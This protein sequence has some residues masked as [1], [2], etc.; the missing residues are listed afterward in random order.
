M[1]TALW[2]CVLCL[3]GSGWGSSSACGRHG[4][5]IVAVQVSVDGWNDARV[6][7][8]LIDHAGERTGWYQG[9]AVRGIPGCTHEFGSE[10]GLPEGSDEVSGEP[11]PARE[12][13][14][15]EQGGAT[16]K[17]HHFTI[18][19]S[20]GAPSVIRRGGCELRLDPLIGGKVHLIL[21]ASD[22]EECRD[23]TSV[24][25]QPGVASRWWLSW[26]GAGNRCAVKI[27]R[28]AALRSQ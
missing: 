10:E 15:P 23:T 4:R 3:L 27:S 12:Y 14:I 22:G 24:W 16:P 1:R 7:A 13:E 11:S 28:K 6:A 8:Y 2:V 19:D 9:R 26:R 17:Y 25:V 5:R 20:T 18:Q 21:I